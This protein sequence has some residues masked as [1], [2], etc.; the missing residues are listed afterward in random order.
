ME[1][2]RKASEQGKAEQRQPAHST[3]GNEDDEW[4]QPER[5][6]KSAGTETEGH[7]NESRIPP[8]L[9]K[10]NLRLKAKAGEGM[11]EW[12]ITFSQAQALRV[13][14]HHGGSISQRELERMLEVSHPTVAG[15]VSRMRKNGFVR[16]T[17][18]PK[19][20]R[21]KIVSFTDKAYR[22]KQHILQQH[23]EV[24]AQLFRGM[25][26]EEIRSA[27]HAL[28]KMYQNIQDWDEYCCRDDH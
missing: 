7:R 15:L 24:D 25:T 11:K 10:I 4:V 5:T 18:D 22:H 17:V 13:I 28:Q 19:D 6:G 3:P 23:L 1:T 16:V 2:E 9:M 14:G 27:E 8:L 21:N 20:H 26:D 12:G